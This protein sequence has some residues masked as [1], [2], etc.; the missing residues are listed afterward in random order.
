MNSA[1]VRPI[2]LLGNASLDNLLRLISGKRCFSHYEKCFFPRE[3]YPGRRI[4]RSPRGA[5]M[6][7]P[8]SY[9][10]SVDARLITARHVS[11]SQ[12]YLSGHTLRSPRKSTWAGPLSCRRVLRAD[13]D[14]WE[15]LVNYALTAVVITSDQKWGWFLTLERICH[16]HS[17]EVITTWKEWSHCSVPLSCAVHSR[18]DSLFSR[19]QLLHLTDWHLLARRGGDQLHLRS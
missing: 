1:R 4:S 17:A 15:S 9:F 10:M 3:R 14:E 18:L 12:K 16:K 13:V 8:K 11:I 5:R 19:L 2:L 6:V 7:G